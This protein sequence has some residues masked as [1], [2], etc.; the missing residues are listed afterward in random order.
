MNKLTEFFDAW[1][2]W[3]SMAS[4]QAIV[5]ILFV[6]T[7]CWLI[8][9]SSQWAQCWLWRLVFLKLVLLLV[10]VSPIQLPILPHSA[11][12]P[13]AS[14]DI[15]FVDSNSTTVSYLAANGD[16]N[17]SESSQ[18]PVVDSE[19]MESFPNSESIE[20]SRHSGSAASSFAT[21]R[22]ILLVLWLTGVAIGIT[23]LSWALYLSLIHI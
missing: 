19:T 20:T 8:Q 11:D 7:T 22:S 14:T 3:L 2:D 4:I 23:I 21:I 10:F 16:L 12:D 17:L 18:A 13:M 5:F 9:K 6:L 1:M 15:E